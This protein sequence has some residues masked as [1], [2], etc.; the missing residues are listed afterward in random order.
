MIKGLFEKIAQVITHRPML[1]AGIIAAVFIVCLYGMSTITMQTN[2]EVYLVKDSVQGQQY[3]RYTTTFQSDPVILLIETDNSLNPDVLQYL[4]GLENSIRQQ[5]NIKDVVGAPDILRQANNGTLPTST[6]EI[7]NAEARVPPETIAAFSKSNLITIIRV[8]VNEGLSDNAKTNLLNNLQSLVDASNPPPGVTVSVTGSA[9]FSQQ[10]RSSMGAST[11]TL[12]FAALILMVIVMGILF[13]Y[14]SHRFLPVLM[15]TIGLVVSMGLM[16]LVGIQLNMAVMGA[17]P[18][19][20][21]LGIDYAIQFHSRFDEE[22]RKGNIEQAVFMTVTRTG[23]AVLYAMLATCMGFVAMFISPVPM[24]QSFGLVAIIGVMCCYLASLVGIPTVAVLLKYKPKERKAGPKKKK[25]FSYGEFLTG[26]SVKISK[27]PVPVLLVAGIIAVIGFQVDGL[28]PIQ[29]NE[30]AFVPPDMPAKVLNDKVT[31]MYGASST[32][33]IYLYGDGVNSLSA[34]KWMK[35][36][37]DDELNRHSELTG[38]T[39]I[40]TYILAYNGGILPDSQSELDTIIAR[41]PA[42]ITKS[43]LSGSTDAVVQFS[44]I[45]L[46]V[47]Q[48][49]TLKKQMIDDI[50]FNPPPPGIRAAPSGSFDLFTSLIGSL[51]SSKEQMTILGFIL[52]FV[53]LGLVY[54]RIDAITPLVPIIIVVGWNA[55]AMYIMGIDY[56]PLTA[57]LGSMTIGVAAEY[58]ILVMERYEEEFDNLGNPL[59]AI[60]HSVERIGTAITVS[61]LATFFGFS[62]LLFASFPI[63]SNFGVSTLIAVGFSLMGAIIIMP[64]IL[65]LMGRLEKP[66]QR[67]EGAACLLPEEERSAGNGEGESPLKEHDSETEIL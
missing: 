62:A 63:V 61:G 8:D 52:V 35:Q 30:N 6:G 39:S 55:I 58:T 7:K 40:V 64:A 13:S 59:A 5:Q 12:I 46:E 16:G 66:K 43:Y 14:V 1:V 25:T 15:V 28:I 37:Q 42:D 9:A 2:W 18:V 11:G 34:I 65:S 51:S 27:N 38:A 33:P 23:P 31:R 3:N 57:T 29:T 67:P 41:I 17:F 20:I 60:Q 49:S 48:E 21:G 4:D 44:T 54:R 32:A 53:F 22:I 24:I 36:F 10:M 50:N 45:S 56:S 26:V 19:L 47:S